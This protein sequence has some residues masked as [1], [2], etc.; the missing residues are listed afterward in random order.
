MIVAVTGA[1]GFVGSALV[2]ELGER[3][4]RVRPIVRELA[5]GKSVAVGD[6]GPETDWRRA[7]DGVDIVVHCAA[8]VHVM[9]EIAAD[10]VAEFERVNAA[11]TRRLVQ[12]AAE[13][14]VRRI[15]YVSSIKV[16]GERTCPNSG[17]AA[18]TAFD[19]PDPQ[20]AYG[21]SKYHAEQALLDPAIT[22]SVE[23][24]IV[25]PPLVYGPG[26]GGN[27]SRLIRLVR[28]GL[29]LPFA[30]VNNSRSLVGIGNLIDLLVL[31]AEHPAAAGQTFLASDGRDLSTAGLIR[32][33]AAAMERS[34]RLFALPLGLLEAAGRFTGRSAQVDRLVES[35]QVDVSHTRKWLDWSPPC[36]VEYEMRRTV[37]VS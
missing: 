16:N 34:P 32:E 27:F 36:S 1:N 15:V 31:C 33:L 17:P 11:G 2:R 35:L 8:R 21:L 24:V 26:V 25:R 18:F 3:S 22:A 37:A 5:G 19:T 10:P 20:D 23:T 12:C 29:P 28:S 14:G 4:Y 7:L 9:E 30:G 6:I 13:A